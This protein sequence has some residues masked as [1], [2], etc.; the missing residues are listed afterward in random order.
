MIYEYWNWVEVKHGWQDNQS[1]SPVGES[2]STP[3]MYEE[4]VYIVDV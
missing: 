1:T 4:F 2:A 3:V